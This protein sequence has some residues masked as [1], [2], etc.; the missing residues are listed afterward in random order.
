[1]S[2]L[3]IREGRAAEILL[4]E[5][6]R[7]DAMLA[8]RAF[9]TARIDNH[10]IV[11]ETGEKALSVLR[12]EGDYADTKTP[13][14]ILLDLNLPKMSGRQVLAAIKGD[15]RLKHIPVIVLSSSEA[16]TDV[17][18]SYDGHANAYIV[19]PIDL[20]KFRDVVASIEEFFFMLAV[21]PADEG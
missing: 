9:K 11:A 3:L 18:G 1:M 6:N 19:K 2:N 20:A 14:L 21:L 16:E 13:D 5:D 4:V 17:S 8:S 15:D 7:G 12:K 10:L